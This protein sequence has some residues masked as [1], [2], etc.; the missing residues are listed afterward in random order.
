[1]VDKLDTRVKEAAAPPVLQPPPYRTAGP[2]QGY[3][4]DASLGLMLPRS[5][6]FARADGD[7]LE[8]ESI[9]DV[10]GF[11]LLRPEWAELLQASDVDCLFLSWEWLFTWWKHLAGARRLQLLTVRRG[12]RLLAIAPLARR[13]PQ[14]ERLLPFSVLEFLGTGIVGSD[15]LDLVIRR[16]AEDEVLRALAAHLDERRLVLELRQVKAASRFASRLAALLQKDGWVTDQTITD[17][18]P[19]LDIA[20]HSWESYLGRVGP[21]HRQNVRRRLRRI[22]G[23]FAVDFEQARSESERQAYLALFVDLHRK[24]W[25]GRQGSEALSGAGIMEFHEEFSRLALQRGWLRLYVLRLERAPAASIYGFRYGRVFYF[26]QSG[27]DPRYR[28]YSVGLV[29]MALTIQSAIGEGASEYDM[30]HGDEGYKFLWARGGRDLVRLD[31]Y[32]PNARGVLCRQAAGLRRGVK[33]AVRWP[34]RLLGAGA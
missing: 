13:P 29:T 14:P 22:A 4:Q 27:F 15:Y 17:V 1:M 20:G 33:Q 19:Y 25:S 21:A 18:C 2:V 3:G 11:A 24:R 32:P 6:T 23:S 7:A 28:E 10:A 26:Y 8:V 9:E 16:G 12:G 30:L 31:C 34:R 5:R